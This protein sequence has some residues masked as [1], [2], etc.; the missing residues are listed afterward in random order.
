MTVKAVCHHLSSWSSSFLFCASCHVIVA[1]MTCNH[2][3]LCSTM[4]A[5]HS[6][7]LFVCLLSICKGSGL[8]TCYSATCTSKICDK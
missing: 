3:T 5:G 8:V 7:H 6:V 4:Y 1:M 2:A